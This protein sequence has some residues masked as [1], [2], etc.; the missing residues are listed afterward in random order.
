MPVMKKDG[1]RKA[2]TSKAPSGLQLKA[3]KP[4][5]AR[6]RGDAVNFLGPVPANKGKRVGLPDLKLPKFDLKL[7]QIRKATGPVTSK[8]GPVEIRQ[9][10]YLKDTIL[11]PKKGKK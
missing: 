11:A 5:K 2:S 7:P 9:P 1:G 4:K 6:A 3:W 8:I 10:R